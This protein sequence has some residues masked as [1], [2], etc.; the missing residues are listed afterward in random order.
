MRSPEPPRPG[1]GRHVVARVG[2]AVLAAV[3]VAA[4]A[5]EN[6]FTGPATGGGLLGPQVDIT[7][8][9][10]NISIAPGDSVNVTATLSSSSGITQVSFTGTLVAGGTAAFTPVVVALTPVNDTT[11][12]RYMKRSGATA[13][14]ARIIVTASDVSGRTSADTI[15]VTL[16]S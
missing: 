3:L 8:P 16:G 15:S 13:G 4:C 12:S 2:A 7:A 14:A 6:L 5:G 1:K 9:Q 10:P 11:M